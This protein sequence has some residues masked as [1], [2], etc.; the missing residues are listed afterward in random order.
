MALFFKP[1]SFTVSPP[2]EGNDYGEGVEVTTHQKPGKALRGMIQPISSDVA[3]QEWAIETTRAVR[4]FAEIADKDSFPV[5]A[6]IHCCSR[7]QWLKV[8]APPLVE[9]AEPI[10]AHIVVPCEESRPKGVP[11]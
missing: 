10:T 9:D 8:I 11:A 2:V 7:N 5:G 1:H 4:V 6:V 3:Y